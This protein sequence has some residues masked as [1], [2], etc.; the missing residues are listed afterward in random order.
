V[1]WLR[2]ATF[3]VLSV[4]LS[5]SA[6]AV[7]SPLCE[8]LTLQELAPGM[9]NDQVRLKMGG[10]GIPSITRQLDR[11]E[12]SIANYP[13]PAVEVLVEY[14]H[15]I[16]SRPAARAV[17]VRVS[18]PLSPSN[19][20]E[21]VHRFGTPDAGADDL[22]DGSVDTLAIWV[23]EPCGIVLTAHPPQDSWW[24]ANGRTIL[25]LETLDAARREDSPARSSLGA[26]LDRQHGVPAAISVPGAP[27]AAVD[28]VAAPL[29]RQ[30]A[31]QDVAPA[32]P[33][34]RPAER[35][36]FVPPVYPR[37]ARWL[38]I[39]G[40]VTLEIVVKANGRVSKKPRIVAEHPTGQ[41]FGQAA[42][43]AVPTWRFSPATRAGKPVK[44]TLTIDVEFK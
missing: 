9:S 30:E 18:M 35:I 8:R 25:Q 39:E 12:T 42:V 31:Q 22:S 37:T 40:H 41:G 4:S 26:I 3:A 24:A 19:V 5:L 14:D 17:L 36:S 28:S 2:S 34:D 16:D 29:P 27:A 1:A 38:K 20:E 23:N 32:T 10:G 43:D 15:R 33:S 21:L 6:G 13:G 11:R 7:S 44:S